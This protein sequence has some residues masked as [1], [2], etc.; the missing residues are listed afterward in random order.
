MPFQTQSPKCWTIRS[1]V[2]SIFLTSMLAKFTG[3]PVNANGQA[4]KK[5]VM[6]D[7]S[8]NDGPDSL[9]C[10]NDFWRFSLAIY[11]QAEVAE[12]CLALQRTL[13]ID[14]N[15]LLFC[16]WLGAGAVT[17]NAKDIAD[18]ST[19]VGAWHHQVVRP[20]RGV[21]QWIKTLNRKEFGRLRGRVKK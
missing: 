8:R 18:A 16:A 1:R 21:R 17:L 11:G 6:R 4:V 2:S 5:P 12:E 15:V 14:V 3:G 20:L 10:D 9:Q 7:Q 19:A 13:G